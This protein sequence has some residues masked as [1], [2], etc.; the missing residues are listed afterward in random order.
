MGKLLDAVKFFPTEDFEQLQ[1]QE[2]FDRYKQDLLSSVGPL[3]KEIILA[4]ANQHGH[5]SY[6]QFIELVHVANLD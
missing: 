4:H 6:D 2:W 3:S 1:Q 5:L